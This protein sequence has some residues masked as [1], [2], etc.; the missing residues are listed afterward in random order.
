MIEAVFHWH[1]FVELITQTGSILID[2]FVTGNSSCDCTV[3]QLCARP[4]L[5]VCLTHGHSDHVGDT[6]Q[7]AKKTWCSVIGMVELCRWLQNHWVQKTESMNRGWTWTGEGRS[8]KFVHASHSSSTP[9]WTYAWLASWLIFTLGQKTIYHS[10]DTGLF[11][12]MSEY[13]KY[14]LDL[15]FLPI[16]DRYTMWADDAL[17]AAE[18]IQAK[19][20]VPIHYDTRPLIQ[21]D[22]Q[23]FARDLMTNAFAVP[24]VLTP[25]QAV[26]LS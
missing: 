25:W 19:I 3:E 24:K 15:A 5:A 23:K 8:V 18:R 6:I 22:E 9:D 26:V 11:A 21:A 10:G 12:E 1:S 13:A 16:G 4:I 7:I 14:H 20:V 2:P 17:I